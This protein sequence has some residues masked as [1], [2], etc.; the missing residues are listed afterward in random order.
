MGVRALRDRVAA[1]EC[2]EPAWRRWVGSEAR[3]GQCT[4]AARSA[5]A[6]RNKATAPA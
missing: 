1:G 3:M 5:R 2:N 4:R 6:Y